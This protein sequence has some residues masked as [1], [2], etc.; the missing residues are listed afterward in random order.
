MYIVHAFEY[1][2]FVEIGFQIDRIV[3]QIRSAKIVIYRT[4]NKSYFE[5]VPTGEYQTLLCFDNDGIPLR[6]I[7]EKKLEF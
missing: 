3:V 5:R 7:F 1:E 2:W 4:N 6:L